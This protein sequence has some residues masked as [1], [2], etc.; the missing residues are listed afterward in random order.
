MAR[1]ASCGAKLGIFSSKR[2]CLRC[3]EWLCKDCEYIA[4]QSGRCPAC[5]RHNPFK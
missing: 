4:G 5:G 2:K 3:G 1:C